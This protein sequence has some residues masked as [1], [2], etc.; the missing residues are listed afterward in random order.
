MSITVKGTRFYPTG[1]LT[2]I[3]FHSF[4]G[5]R[6]KHKIPVVVQLLS[7]VWLFVNP[8]TAACQASLSFTISQS[9]FKLLSIESVM[10]SNCLIL[11]H[12]LLLLPSI[13]SNIRAFS[14]ELAL[15][16][17]WPKYWSSQHQS[18]QWIF[19]VD[20]LQDWLVWSP[21]C[22]RDSPEASPAPQFEI[23]LSSKI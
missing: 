10:P 21:C 8:R 15:C 9:L 16:I 14:N 23:W 18:F 3:P 17:R 12:P 1:Q 5:S 13:F 19:R 7:P 20:F 22:P 11:C 4:M 2:S 6:R